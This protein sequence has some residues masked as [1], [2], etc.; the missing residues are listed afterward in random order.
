[1]NPIPIIISTIVSLFAKDVYDYVK[2]DD[3][4]EMASLLQ[5]LQKEREKTRRQAWI[6]AIL[7]VILVASGVSYW[8]WHIL[9]SSS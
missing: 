7:I 4:A 6:I 2:G 8:Y 3:D 5:L 9:T 1:M